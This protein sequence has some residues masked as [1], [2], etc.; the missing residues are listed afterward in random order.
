M[1]QSQPFRKVLRIKYKHK[2]LDL[3]FSNDY[4]GLYHLTSYEDWELKNRAWYDRYDMR[5]FKD[6]K[7]FI[8]CMQSYEAKP[9]TEIIEYQI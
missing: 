1:K 3:V 9:S 6:F 4:E 7:H 8:K 2:Y 5:E